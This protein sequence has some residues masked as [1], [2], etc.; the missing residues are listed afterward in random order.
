MFFGTWLTQKTTLPTKKHMGVFQTSHLHGVQLI[1]LKPAGEQPGMVD[2]LLRVLTDV[3][4]QSPQC[5]IFRSRR[6]PVIPPEIFHVWMVWFFGGPNIPNLR[7]WPWMSRGFWMGG[8]VGYLLV[9]WTFWKGSVL[10]LPSWFRGTW[11][12]LLFISLCNWGKFP[13]N[14]DIFTK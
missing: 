13:L 2:Y 3:R 6:L 4:S 7:R 8:L 12:Y 5:G 1:Q 10:F 11:V 9:N 14:H